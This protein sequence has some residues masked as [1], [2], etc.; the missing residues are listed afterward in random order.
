MLCLDLVQLVITAQ[1]EQAIQSHALLD[2]TKIQLE[3]TFAKPV[4]QVITVVFQ[5]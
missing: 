1:W 3:A 5:V 4:L 2:T